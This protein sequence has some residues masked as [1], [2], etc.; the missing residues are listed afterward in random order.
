[1]S[2]IMIVTDIGYG[3][4]GKGSMVDYLA[5]QAK[6][7]LVVRYNG[8]P[9]AAHN[10]ITPDGRHHTFAQMG[11]ASFVDGSRTHLSR[12]MLV[13]PFNLTAEIEHLESLG[14]HGLWERLTIDEAAIIITPWHV[15]ANRLREMARANDRHGSCGQGIGEAKLDAIHFPEE[16]LIARDLRSPSI[17]RQKLAWIRTFKQIQLHELLQKLPKS[18]RAQRELEIIESDNLMD[19]CLEFYTTFSKRAHIVPGETLFTLMQQVDQTLFEGAQGVLLDENYGFHPYTTWS[20]TTSENA[21]ILLSEGGH[22]D[23]KRLAVMRA[24]MSR[25]GAGP[26]VT[27]DRSLSSAIPDR[28]NVTNEWQAQFRVGHLDFVALS[29]ALAA[30]GGADELIVTNL[31][32]LLELDSW[33]TCSEYLLPTAHTDSPYFLRDEA[34]R[35]I[36]IR[37]GPRN[38]RDY[39]EAITKTLLETKPVLSEAMLNDQ[40][41][42]LATIEKRLGV[43]L[44]YVSRGVT[45]LEKHRMHL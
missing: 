26:F 16:A 2:E 20:V 8:G 37:V 29:Y 13:N 33:Q 5:R 4:A 9:Q 38:R 14:A 28:H 19:V 36:G 44:G 12:F 7:N 21:E 15:A 6:S 41:Q 17:M 1:M 25:H 27:E 11:S 31:D 22:R 3:D 45:A 18:E 23:Y 43:R 30:T 32:R 39:Q 10:V 35:V 42:Y 34:R 40:E 24:Y